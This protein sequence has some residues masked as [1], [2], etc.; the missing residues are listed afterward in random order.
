MLTWHAQHL[1]VM[2]WI[3]SCGSMTSHRNR[4][5]AVSSRAAA[6]EKQ[7]SLCSSAL[8]CRTCGIGMR[9]CFKHLKVMP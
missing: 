3:P 6:A 5:A 7:H 1:K 8:H 4:E 9:T 2:P